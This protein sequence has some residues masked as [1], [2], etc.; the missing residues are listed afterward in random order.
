MPKHATALLVLLL[1]SVN[2]WG[3]LVWTSAERAQQPL[4]YKVDVVSEPDLGFDVLMSLRGEKGWRPVSCRRATDS[5]TDKAMYECVV[6]RA[7][8]P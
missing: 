5:L 8:R 7:Y 3:A 6:E 2:L 1:V 4:A